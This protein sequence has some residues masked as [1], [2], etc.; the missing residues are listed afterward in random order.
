MTMS[1]K[2]S[3]LQGLGVE[4]MALDFRVPHHPEDSQPTHTWPSDLIA[5]MG[6]WKMAL[7]F[8][9]VEEPRIDPPARRWFNRRRR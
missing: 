3:R 1:I 7:V 6:R 5:A 4:D 9:V 2:L 8:S